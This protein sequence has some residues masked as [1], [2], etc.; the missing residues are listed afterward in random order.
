MIETRE[1]QRRYYREHKEKLREYRQERGKNP[2][3]KQVGGFLRKAPEDLNENQSWLAK[4][5]G[6]SRER[7]SKYLK[8]VYLPKKASVKE[9][10]CRVLKIKNKDLESLIDE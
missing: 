2:P 1:Y 4:Q 6:I 5:L 7:V 3:Y 9:K 10:L 8:G